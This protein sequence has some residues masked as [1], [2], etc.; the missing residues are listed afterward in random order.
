MD[1]VISLN[2]FLFGMMIAAGSVLG[3]CIFISIFIKRNVNWTNP[4]NL[5]NKTY[6][7]GIK[8]SDGVELFE[9]S[10]E[11]DRSKFIDHMKENTPELRYITS[12]VEG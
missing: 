12:E 6:L 8:L 5:N 1:S 3:V 9:F 2:Q 10:N 7:I 4:K 11:C